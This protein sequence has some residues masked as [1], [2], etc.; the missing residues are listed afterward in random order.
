MA[1]LVRSSDPNGQDIRRHAAEQN[2]PVAIAADG[3]A[4]YWV[5]RG[6]GEVVRMSR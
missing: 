1:G 3:D 4:L 5:N 2:D 6:S